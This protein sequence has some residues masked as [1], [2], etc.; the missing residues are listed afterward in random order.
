MTS[1]PVAAGGSSPGAF[2]EASERYLLLADISGYTSFLSAVEDSHGVDF[3]QGIPAGYTIIGALLDAVVDGVQP[4]FDVAKLEGDAVFAT[5]TADRLDG[6]GDRLVELLRDVNRS[7][8]V[9]KARQAVLA[10]D[11]VCT[12]CPRAAALTVKMILHRGQVVAVPGRGVSDI[13]GPAVTLAHRLLKNSVRSHVGDRP[14]LLLT[15]SAAS[16]LG[17][18]DTGFAHQERYDDVGV[19]EGRVVELA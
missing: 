10:S 14:Y 17:L 12:G 11:H 1:E 18:D 2:V 7:F 13:H 16:A 4:P 3:S 5:A 8:E 15:S 6:D 9:V 19:V